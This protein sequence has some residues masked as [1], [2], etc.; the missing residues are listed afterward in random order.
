MTSNWEAVQLHDGRLAALRV[1]TVYEV[2]VNEYEAAERMVH[3][4]KVGSLWNVTENDLLV[5][6]YSSETE[7]KSAVY[8]HLGIIAVQC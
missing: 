8:R 4:R 2:F 6:N 7:A 1:K 5:G 3:V